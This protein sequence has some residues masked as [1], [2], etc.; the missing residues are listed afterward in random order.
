MVSEDDDLE[1][2]GV[3][4]FSGKNIS[5]TTRT[6]DQEYSYNPSP[7]SLGSDETSNVNHPSGFSR[8]MMRTSWRSFG[9]VPARMASVD[10]VYESSRG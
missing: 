10:G 3:D 2:V 5:I 4:W 9:P 7:S 8:V 1:E 6:N